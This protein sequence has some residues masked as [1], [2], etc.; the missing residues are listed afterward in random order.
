[1][2]FV[3]VAQDIT[4]SEFTPVTQ[5]FLWIYKLSLGSKIVVILGIVQ[6]II[7]LYVFNH[8]DDDDAAA[9]DDDG[10]A[11]EEKRPFLETAQEFNDPLSMNMFDDPEQQAAD[12]RNDDRQSPTA[13]SAKDDDDMVPAKGHDRDSQQ[14]QQQQLN[15][16]EVSFVRGHNRRR[17]QRKEPSGGIPLVRNASG[18]VKSTVKTIVGDHLIPTKKESKKQRKIKMLLIVDKITAICFCV[19][20]GIFLLIMFLI[21][22]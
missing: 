22:K 20:Y 4:M 11:V 13:T 12:S 18:A 9:D 15:K 16:K 10:A 3:M 14:Q 6:S 17:A 8:L 5:E 7:A 19:A 1:M 2:L 21:L